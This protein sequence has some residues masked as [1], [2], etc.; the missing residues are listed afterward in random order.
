MAMKTVGL[1]VLM[2]QMGILY[3]QAD[4]TAKFRWSIKFCG[5]YRRPP[6]LEQI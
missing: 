1:L 3:L 4:P 2:T 5:R 6:S